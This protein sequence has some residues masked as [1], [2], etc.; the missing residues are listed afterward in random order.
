MQYGFRDEMSCTDAIAATTDYMRVMIDKILTGQA[1]FIDLK[2]NF[3]T[4]GRTNF[5]ERWKNLD[6]EEKSTI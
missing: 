4:S 1:C 5:F 3:D 6:Y 2:K